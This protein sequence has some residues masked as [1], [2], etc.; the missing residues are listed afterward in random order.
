[1]LRKSRL[2]GLSALLCGTLLANP[3]QAVVVFLSP[4]SPV[5]VPGGYQY[6]YQGNFS[7]DEGVDATSRLVIFDFAGYIPGSIAA[8]DAAIT[9]T[10]EMSSTGLPI[11]G[12]TDDPTLPNLVFSYTGSLVDLSNQSF[13]GLSALSSFGTTILD[14]F[15]GLT[16]KLVGPGANTQV[17]SSGLVAVPN[18]VSPTPVPEPGMLGLMAAGLGLMGV[19]MRIR[20]RE[21]QHRP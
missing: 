13:A 10:I 4:G 21:V 6:N 15:S 12:F 18:A 17:G 5:A 1:M 19:A 16:M 14:G 7:N 3:A 2:L 8:T 9:P 20:R 11:F